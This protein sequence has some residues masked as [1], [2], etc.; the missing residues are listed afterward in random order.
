LVRV[1]IVDEITFTGGVAK[2][3]GM[4]RAVEDKLKRKLN[5]SDDSH[6]MGALGAALFALDSLMS[7]DAS[8]R[9]TGKEKEIA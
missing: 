4:I 7:G 8:S 1:G 2:N 3:V 6:F 9:T 5:V